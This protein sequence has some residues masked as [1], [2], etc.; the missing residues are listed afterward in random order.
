VRTR[1]RHVAFYEAYSHMYGGAQRIVHLLAEHLPDHGFTT[2]IV[3]A[4]PGVL[5]ERAQA[6]GVDVSVVQV[7]PALDHYGRSTTGSRVPRAVAAL[8]GY[9]RALAE[10]LRQRP[11]LVHG[12]SQRSVLLAAPAARLARAR[13][14][15]QVSV[16]EDHR[17]VSLLCDTLAHRT[18][19]LAAT[20]RVPSLR[21]WRDQPVIFPPLAPELTDAVDDD[22][23]PLA[24][25][26]TAVA[27]ARLEPMKQFDLLLRALARVRTEIPDVQLQVVG[28][29]QEGHEGYARDVYGLCAALDLDDHVEFLGFT[30]RPQDHWRS[31]WLHVQPGRTEGNSLAVMEA[32]ANRVAV[33]VAGTTGNAAVV[34]GT[35][36]GHVVP[37]DDEAA[38]AAAMVDVLRDPSTAARLGDRAREVA[39]ERYHVARIAAETAQL[40]DQY[41]R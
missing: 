17:A 31:A 22:P 23:R 11:G 26:P 16:L 15:W 24:T 4:R 10:H 37:P 19:G 18:T 30:P 32:M 38:L 7:P 13:F 25:R 39:V 1:P 27:A 21:P 36:S 20:L 5:V 33:V 12:C 3:A 40:Y 34:D 2:E 8:P 9:W 6:S 29:E 14:V 28:G 35:G 41:L